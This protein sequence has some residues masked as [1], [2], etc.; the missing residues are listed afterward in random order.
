MR[1][2]VDLSDYVTEGVL[3]MKCENERWRP[4]AFLS[5]SLNKIEKNYEIHDVGSDKRIR[6]L[7]AFI[8][9]CKI[10]FEV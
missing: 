7:E 4:V 1:M 6:K 2:K 8:R 5:K 10:K 3:L 9:G